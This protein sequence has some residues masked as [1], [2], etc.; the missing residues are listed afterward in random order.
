MPL[1]KPVNWAMVESAGHV[2]FNDR[3]VLTHELWGMVV[4]AVAYL[5]AP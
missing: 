3:L 5:T 2:C 4:F 1:K